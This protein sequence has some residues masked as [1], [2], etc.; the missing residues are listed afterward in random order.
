MA[1]YYK[2]IQE[3]EAVVKGF[4]SCITPKDDFTHRSHLTVATYYLHG[5]N[6]A[7]ATQS[8]RAALLR[9]LD[10][11]GVGRSKFH[12]T[13]T[14]FW[15]RTV[16]AFLEHLDQGLSLL[17]V[18]NAVVESLGNSRLVFEYYSDELLWREETR[19]RWVEPDLN[20]CRRNYRTTHKPTS[21]AEA[22]HP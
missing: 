18:T 10:H 7:D 6:Q 22:V 8:M 14:I 4:E 16:W 20:S 15:I 17:E 19:S 12:E 1:A 13:L 9:F 2:Q 11:H 21:R 3:I 5:S